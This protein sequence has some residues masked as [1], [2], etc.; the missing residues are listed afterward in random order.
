[1]N[2]SLTKF[3][4]YALEKKTSCIM[5][6]YEPNHQKLLKSGI[7]ILDEK[8]RVQEMTEKSQP[9]ATN[10]CVPAFYYYIAENAVRIAEGI[11]F[12]CRTDAPGNYV[13]WLCTR[14]PIHTMEMLPV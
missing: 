12:G 10:W 11:A 6:Y 9:P 8:E 13:A 14:S 4:V 3:I 1:M 7:V 5:R 2:I